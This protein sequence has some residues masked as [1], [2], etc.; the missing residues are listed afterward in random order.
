[1]VG[2]K[3]EI[4]GVALLTRPPYLVVCVLH[5]I[6]DHHMPRKAILN[7]TKLPIGRQRN[8]KNHS[9]AL[10]EAEHVYLMKEALRLKC[11]V[12][13]IVRTALHHGMKG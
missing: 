9:I 10:T 11:S 2:K 5:N 12:S 13:A 8:Y 1:M 6:K 3:I 4:K 7:P